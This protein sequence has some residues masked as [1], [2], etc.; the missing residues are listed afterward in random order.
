LCQ[1]VDSGFFSIL[2]LGVLWYPKPT[3]YIMFEVL[4]EHPMAR[5]KP[6]GATKQAA[7]KT[8]DRVS[9]LLYKGSTEYRD[10]LLAS[11]KTKR[12]PATVVVDV[13][14][15]EWAARNGLPEPPER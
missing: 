2:S 11:A 7:E 4:A 10:W 5:T 6:K 3:G 8:D 9:I 14:L 12:M 13:A 1:E 15:A